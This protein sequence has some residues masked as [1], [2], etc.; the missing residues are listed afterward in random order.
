MRLTEPRSKHTH[1][2]LTCFFEA[3][4]TMSGGHIRRGGFLRTL[5]ADA[6]A[7]VRLVLLAFALQLAVP[8]LQW[9]GV[10]AQAGE[11]GLQADLLSSLCHDSG[12]SDGAGGGAAQDSSVKHCIFCMPMAGGHLAGITLPPSPVPATLRGKLLPVR[13]A[14]TRSD[15]DVVFAWSRAPPP[16]PRS[17]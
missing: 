13:D 5:R 6:A 3:R 17:V 2:A 12:P 11:A 7:I 10:A 9:G 16:S 14:Q 4:Q 8:A 15:R 1:F